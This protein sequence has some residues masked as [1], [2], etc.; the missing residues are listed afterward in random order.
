[1]LKII[2][3]N[4]RN[5][6]NNKIRFMRTMSTKLIGALDQGT[7]STRFIVFDSTT[8]KPLSVQQMDHQQYYPRPGWVEHDPI[9]ILNNSIQ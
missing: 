5:N 6:R 8:L 3:N 4:N 1:M 7:T 9:E 2:F